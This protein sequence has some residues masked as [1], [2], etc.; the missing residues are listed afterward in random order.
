MPAFIITYGTEKINILP[1]IYE[2]F[3]F[4]ECRAE[5]VAENVAPTGAKLQF[6]YNPEF[7]TFFGNY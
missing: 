6:V 3:T 2:L 4:A 7:F 1:K 5:R